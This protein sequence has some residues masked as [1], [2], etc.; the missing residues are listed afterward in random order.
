M[1]LSLRQGSESK[2]ALISNEAPGSSDMTRADGKVIAAGNSH[3]TAPA[4]APSAV[5]VDIAD[6]PG[7][8]VL[9]PSEYTAPPKPADAKCRLCGSG[10]DADMLMKPCRCETFVHRDC[11]NQQRAMLEHTSEFVT[12][13]TCQYRYWI[14]I[15]E[16]YQPDEKCCGKP[17]RIWKFRGMVAR[18]TAAIFILLQAIIVAYACV[19]ERI[20]SCGSLQGCGQGCSCD[21]VAEFYKCPVDV[22]SNYPCGKGAYFPP[23][24]NTSVIYGGPLLNAFS[25][26]GVNGHYKTTYYFAG[27]LFFLASI[28]VVACCHSG[29]YFQNGGKGGVDGYTNDCVDNYTCYYCFNDCPCCWSHHSSFGC[30]CY[31]HNY[32]PV[33]YRPTLARASGPS[34]HLQNDPCLT[35]CANCNCS[36]GSG[37]CGSSGGGD[38]KCDNCSGGGGGDGAAVLLVIV[39]I[40]VLIFALIGFIYGLILLTLAITK[41]V[42]KHY[43]VAQRRV[44]TRNYIVRDLH[45]IYL[46]PPG[47]DV[48]QLPCAPPIN[49]VELASFGLL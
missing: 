36:G 8:K 25:I 7:A 5:V 2:T 14:D 49:E 43:A 17:A 9:D 26:F 27:L 15:K 28:G 42:Q 30:C 45:G 34:M 31:G 47:Q 39:V 44:M 41:I 18:D 46:P 19:V 3:M 20:D 16:E 21:A 32:R 35:C 33:R 24:I 40:I 1:D 23:P 22:P 13:R 48:A 10:A 12:C 6:A 29:C 11:L 37:N 38:C 4:T